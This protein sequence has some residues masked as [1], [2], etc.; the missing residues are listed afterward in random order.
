MQYYI[1]VLTNHLTVSQ[2]FNSFLTGKQNRVLL[3]NYILT[4]LETSILANGHG[5]RCLI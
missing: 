1:S 4:S 5:I 3:G 2:Q